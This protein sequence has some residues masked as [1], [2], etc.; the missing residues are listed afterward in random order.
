ML[1]LIIVI[2]ASKPKSMTKA[3]NMIP[4]RGFENEFIKPK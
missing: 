1:N 4:T 2:I 3:I